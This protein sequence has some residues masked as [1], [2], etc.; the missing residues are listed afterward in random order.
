MSKDSAKGASSGFIFQF[1]EAL[2]LLSKLEKTDS[3]S[4]EWVDDVAIHDKDQNFIITVQAKNSI[5]PTGKTFQ[6]G[7][8]AL[9]RTLEIWIN[10]IEDGT[11]NTET[12]FI[13]CTNKKVTSSGILYKLKHDFTTAFKN[14]QEKR[15]TLNDN[16]SG[17]K[18]SSKT[19]KL[20]QIMDYVI[21]HSS[22][23]KS[24]SSR[25]QIQ[26]QDEPIKNKLFNTL[27]LNSSKMNDLQRNSIFEELYG[28][29]V[30]V[31]RAKWENGNEAIISKKEFDTKYQFI[32]NNPLIVDAI[33]RTKKQL[34]NIYPINDNI[35]EEHKDLIFV[36]QIIDIIKNENSREIFIKNAI[37][38][39]FYSEKEIAELASSGES[40]TK[41]D[42][43]DFI[44]MCYEKW[45]K[46][47]Y[48]DLLK[49]ID[50]Y[51]EQERIDFGR[52]IYIKIMESIKIEMN[53]F[54]FND[55]NKYI[56]NG[57]FLK[58]SNKPQIG[59][60]PDWEQK[61]KVNG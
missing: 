20:L 15:K 28:W 2:Y 18:V 27:C 34:A 54:I 29:I 21:L 41:S 55:E 56:Q 8:Y 61:Y 42:F 48:S 24:I 4:V 7:S 30:Q 52:K 23:L 16:S 57:T 33:F 53:I 43:D 40:I 44:N 3:I 38:D 14:M 51:S 17:K 5:L 1:E 36:Q 12:K 45:E 22:T 50:E 39:F 26:Y 60:R 31:S 19:S 13:C 11:F 9:W 37:I 6:D 59:W 25:I 47:F 58:L 46:Y 32:R 49:N 35:L 10:K